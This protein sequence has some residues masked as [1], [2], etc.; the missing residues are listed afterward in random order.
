[1]EEKMIGSSFVVKRVMLLCW[2]TAAHVY[3]H[4]EKQWSWGVWRSQRSLTTFINHVVM[5][6]AKS[7][8]V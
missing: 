7:A 6:T 3:D 2:S 8:H 4:E 1:M 5:V